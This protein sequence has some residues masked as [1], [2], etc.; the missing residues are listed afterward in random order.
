V[1][2][3][4]RLLGLS[5]YRSCHQRIDL[6]Q[7][8]NAG[9]RISMKVATEPK[10][11]A[12]ILNWNNHEDTRKCLES[13]EKATYPNLAII[14]VDNGSVDG[15]G[16]RLKEEFSNLRFIFNDKNLGFARGCNVGIRAAL[17]DE[18]CG[19]VLLLN[20]DAVATPGFLKR[21]VETGETNR[22]VGLIGGKIL[23]SPESKR[24]WY[25]GGEINRWRGLTVIR[26]FREVD[27]GQYDSASEVGFVTGAL[28][29]IPRQVLDRVGLLPEEYFFGTEEIDYSIAVKKAGY[30][31]YYVPEFL[32]YHS[33]DGSHSNYDPKF[34]YNNYRGKLIL[35]EKYLPKKLFPLWKKVFNVYGVLAAGR[36]WQRLRNAD[37]DLE[38]K[39]VP[40]HDLRFAF[41]RALKDHGTNSLSEEA[42]TRFDEAL[43]TRKR[44]PKKTGLVKR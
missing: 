32:I 11:Y 15:S 37:P 18:D 27:Q 41:S 43:K 30:K 19:Y 13:L 10:V 7:Q 28:M 17:E 29:L 12:V 6:Y 1:V 5:G 16:K 23:Y 20:N 8:E 44:R 38:D 4:V 33:A 42:L 14:V 36:V 40:F 22:D 26:G 21:A 25:A 9:N 34:V 39:T 2:K 3:Q 24:I 31:L 35:Q